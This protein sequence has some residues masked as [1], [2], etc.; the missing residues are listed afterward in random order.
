MG[1]TLGPGFEAMQ[2]A[3]QPLAERA[4]ALAARLVG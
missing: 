2:R 4:M 1:K 3:A